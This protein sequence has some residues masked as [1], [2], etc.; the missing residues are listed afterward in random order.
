MLINVAGFGLDI[1]VSIAIAQLL[2][3]FLGHYGTHAVTPVI[4]SIQL[5]VGPE[6][7]HEQDL[8]GGGVGSHAHLCW[9]VILFRKLLPVTDKLQHTG[10]VGFG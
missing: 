3:F 1:Q 5:S 8:T 9:I 7:V 6:R 10:V 2:H 4:H